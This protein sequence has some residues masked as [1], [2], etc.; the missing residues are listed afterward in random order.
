[1]NDADEVFILVLM[2]LQWKG[3]LTMEEFL[4]VGVC[5]AIV[6]GIFRALDDVYFR[7]REEVT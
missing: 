2:I 7:K 1:M 5:Y 4:V 3:V 6:R